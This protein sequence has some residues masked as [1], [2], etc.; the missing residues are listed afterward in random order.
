[1]D[2]VYLSIGSHLTLFMISWQT[3]SLFCYL[4]RSLFKNFLS[5]K[6][7]YIWKYSWILFGFYIWQDC[8]VL[9]LKFLLMYMFELFSPGTV[10]YDVWKVVVLFPGLLLSLVGVGRGL[11]RVLTKSCL[12]NS[13][14]C[15]LLNIK[16]IDT[17]FSSMRLLWVCVYVY[18][19]IFLIAL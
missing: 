15:V 17:W 11:C 5:H 6:N 9:L 8:C 10:G 19:L 16:E 13:H 2:V 18:V 14:I 3:L 7:F 1:M 4:Y 12:L